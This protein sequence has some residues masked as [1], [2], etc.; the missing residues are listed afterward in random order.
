[1]SD[2][3]CPECENPMILY[4]GVE[5]DDRGDFYECPDC[6]YDEDILVDGQPIFSAK[7]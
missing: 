6:G 1:M 4:E 3:D 2:E 5:G 7:E